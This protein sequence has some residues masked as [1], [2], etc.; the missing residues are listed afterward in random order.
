MERLV[1]YRKRSLLLRSIGLVLAL[2]A[3]PAQAAT[4]TGIAAPNGGLFTPSDLSGNGRVVVG[5]E[6]NRAVRWEAGVATSLYSPCVGCPAWAYIETSS[7]DGGVLGGMGYRWDHGVFSPLQAPGGEKWFQTGG[8]SD[9]GSVMVGTCRGGFCR[10]EGGV[11]SFF[12]P[13]PG[14]DSTLGPPK[15][16]ADGS[17]FAASCRQPIQ[18]SQDFAV[19]WDDG[20][21]TVLPGLTPTSTSHALGL[22]ADGAVIVGESSNPTYR[23]VYWKDGAVNPLPFLPAQPD[24]YSSASDASA[25]GSVIVGRADAVRVTHPGEIPERATLWFDGAA[26]RIDDLLA[27]QGVDLTGWTLTAAQSVS[28]DGSTIVGMGIDPDQV[29]RSWIAHLD[30]CSNGLDD[31]R[32]G[33]ADDADAGCTS[34][35]DPSEL[36][37]ECAVAMSQPSYGD[38]DQVII[39]DL[40]FANAETFAVP[41]RL[42]LQLTLPIG[43]TANVLDLGAADPF[44]ILG[45]FD[46]QLGSITMFRVGPQIPLRGHF[47]WRCALEDPATGAVLFEKRAPFELQ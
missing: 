17:V 14:L 37:V 46:Q 28:D 18:P 10:W 43:I 2:A 31:D 16:S 40:R 24:P 4:F 12:A 21:A 11:S 13:P 8:V 32:D 19:R 23:A 5:A 42:Q 34:P 30:R 6:S 29:E 47:E 44:E 36:G 1:Q 35:T 3:A 22:S 33:A 45:S 7:F 9:N 20:V 25:D 27:A 39:S 26:H 41:V 15:S 38:G